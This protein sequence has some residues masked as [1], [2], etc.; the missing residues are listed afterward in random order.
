[1]IDSYLA[2]QEAGK[3]DSLKLAS[4]FTYMENNK[5]ADIKTG[6]LSKALKLNHNKTTVDTVDCATYTE[7]IAV[8]GPYVIATQLRHATGDPAVLT[9][10]DSI[11][12]TTGALAFNASRTL[13]LIGEENWGPIAADKLDSR[14]TLKNTADAYLNMWD[15][16]TAQAA[17]PW[18]NPCR[19][20]E[21]SMLVQP[22]CTAGAPNGGNTHINNR[23]YV[24]D[25]TLGSCDVL[26]NFGSIADSHE[27]RLENG[28]LVYIHTVTLSR[29]Q[30]K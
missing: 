29:G 1:V 30:S 6:V 20:V 4:N 23:R 18:G 3:I 21:G 5:V 14:T 19:R 15:N 7:L 9:A 26:C 11:V 2:A 25:E 27:F 28:K 10:I 17:V 16:S 13:S 22:K 12:A 8:T 24:I